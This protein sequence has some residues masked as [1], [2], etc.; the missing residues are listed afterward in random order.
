[1]SIRSLHT[2]EDDQAAE[3]VSWRENPISDKDHGYLPPRR[4]FPANVYRKSLL[5]Q[6]ASGEYH[7][8]RHDRLTVFNALFFACFVSS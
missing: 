4:K 6:I 5:K 7:V 2:E 3:V 1:M 8:H